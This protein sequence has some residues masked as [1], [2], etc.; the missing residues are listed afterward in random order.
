[1]LNGHQTETEKYINTIVASVVLGTY[2]RRVRVCNGFSILFIHMGTWAVFSILIAELGAGF[3]NLC[4]SV[5]SSIKRFT[6][7]NFDM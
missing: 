7:H 2:L 3:Y 6:K 1:M 4:V 5:K